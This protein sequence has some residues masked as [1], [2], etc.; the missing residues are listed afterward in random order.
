M[1][2]FP[3]TLER[4]FFTRLSVISNPD[5]IE[6]NE[7]GVDATLDSSIDVKQPLEGK[8]DF[9]IAEQRVKLDSSDNTK[10]PYSLDVE[11]I[12]FFKVDS[13]LEAE[14]RLSA[15]TMV[16]HNVLYSAVRETILAATARQAWGP[17]SIGL[18]VLR[19]KS[20]NVEQKQPSKKPKVKEGKVTSPIRS[21]SKPK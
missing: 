8:G 5:H 18:S 11:C 7:G 3:I 14:Q 4:Y 2:Q 1:Q 15:V 21:P 9:F 17:F 6:D 12:G 20:P 16:A 10:L 19:N 13:S